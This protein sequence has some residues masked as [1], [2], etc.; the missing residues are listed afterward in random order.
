LREVHTHFC[1]TVIRTH[2]L[3]IA[4]MRSSQLPRDA[5]AQPM[6]WH[7]FVAAHPVKALE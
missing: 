5:Q 7:A 4:A 6:S 3:D 1:P 2:Q